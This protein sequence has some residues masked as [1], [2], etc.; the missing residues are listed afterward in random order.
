MTKAGTWRVTLVHGETGA[1]LWR[2]SDRYRLGTWEPLASEDEAVALA[3]DRERRCWTRFR[4][5]CPP[6][7]VASVE[8]LPPLPPLR[9]TASSRPI[10]SR[11]EE[12][13][14]GGRA[15]AAS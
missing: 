8:Y 14:R 12:A 4:E 3:L 10:A 7:A 9:A 15:S 5:P 1:R 11:S 6:L 2:H 13:P